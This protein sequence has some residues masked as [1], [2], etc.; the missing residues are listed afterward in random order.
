M[1]CS[2]SIMPAHRIILILALTAAIGSST[3][4]IA[5]SLSALTWDEARKMAGETNPSLASQREA[6]EQARYNYQAARAT[7]W[8]TVSGSAG[9][10]RSDSDSQPGGASDRTS[11]GLSAQ[12]SLFSGFADQARVQQAEASLTRATADWI[13]AQADVSAA[14]RRAF[15]RL[16]YAQQR[17]TMTE[18]IVQ[19]RRQNLD[20][21]QLRFDSGS[22]NKGSLL[23]T[24]ATTSQAAADLEQARRGIAVQQRELANALGQSDNDAWIVQGDWANAAPESDPAWKDLARATPAV[25]AAEAGV[26]GNK[27]SVIIARGTI[28]PDLSLR[29]GIDRSGDD[30]PPDND[31]W[32]VGASLS[33]PLFAG[34]QNINK[35]SAAKAALRQSEAQLEA[36]EQ[37]ALLDLKTAWTNLR[38]AQQRRAVQAEFLEAA[39]VRAEIARE[40][41]ANGLLSFQNWDQIEDEL[42]QSQ[43]SLLSSDRDA[44][45]A[46]AEWDRA[47]GLSIIPLP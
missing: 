40:Q 16:L 23:R 31:S 47:R 30:W 4:S 37:S 20:L 29:G 1:V 36:A 38:D 35:L 34:G 21:V 27:A 25:R 14:L 19:R 12:Y 24:K 9:Y 46:A 8:P 43:Q 39:E 3:R 17:V 10:T 28:Y 26:E 2:L 45:I 18:S 33:V 22:E 32:S 42:I 41:Y 15:L 6:L 44:A 13:G 5:D 11:M 7:Y